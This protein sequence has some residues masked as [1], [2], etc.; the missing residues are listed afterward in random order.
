[1][2]PG[3]KLIHKAH[4]YLSL[5]REELKIGL[6][7]SQKPKQKGKKKYSQAFICPLEKITVFI[8]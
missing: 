2:K 1:M 8:K 6:R 5:D 7:A 4:I 3:R